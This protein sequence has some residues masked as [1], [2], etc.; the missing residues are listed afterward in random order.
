MKGDE[1]VGTVYQMPVVD[2]N[3][4]AFRVNVQDMNSEQIAMKNTIVSNGLEIVSRILSSTG[5]T[6]RIYLAVSDNTDFTFYL[7]YPSLYMYA[8]ALSSTIYYYHEELPSGIAR[9]SVI[10]I[11]DYFTS[12][13]GLNADIYSSYNI[14]IDYYNTQE[15][16][17]SALFGYSITY[18]YTNS[19]VSG[20]SKAVIGD[21]VAVSAV[22]D[23]DYGITDQSSQIA[24]TC[25]DEP[26]AF[27]WDAS[28]N[29]ITF[30]MPDST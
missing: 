1:N 6:D 27:S 26:V 29:R 9:L 23:V 11:T 12:Y 20:P 25:N 3:F 21:T 24:V 17:Y 14:L 15:E 2:G 16:A 10:P 4:S 7:D 28:T 18:H 13:I 22:P 19:T 8:K 5:Y 30:T